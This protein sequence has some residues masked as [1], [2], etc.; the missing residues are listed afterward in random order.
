MS[1]PLEILQ[2]EPGR[3]HA[4]SMR[5]CILGTGFLLKPGLVVTCD[6][7]LQKVHTL[8]GPFAVAN[9]AGEAFVFGAEDILASDRALD[10]A[11]IR[12]AAF[13]LNSGSFKLASHRPKDGRGLHYQSFRG[14]QSINPGKRGPRRRLRKAL[15]LERRRRLFRDPVFG[16]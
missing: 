4:S 14:Q 9:I 16:L 15:V 7:V 2:I 5:A 3:S 6:H 13:P 12:L 1:E 10:L 8:H 11:L